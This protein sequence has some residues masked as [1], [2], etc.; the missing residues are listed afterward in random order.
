MAGIGT[1]P[2]ITGIMPD[3]PD[4][5]GHMN[6]N[7]NDSN[8]DYKKSLKTYRYADA[9]HDFSGT[10]DLYDSDDNGLNHGISATM[11][12]L[13]GRY[14]N[15][16]Y[17]AD[18]LNELTNSNNTSLT[19]QSPEDDFIKRLTGYDWSILK[20]SIPETTIEHTEY[21]DIW[22]SN[23]LIKNGIP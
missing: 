11:S 5:Q 21:M 20:S 14:P 10:T 23:N 9:N 13:L 18:E 19:N 1:T 7:R 15:I 3:N 8:Q 2:E 4:L 12:D 17:S 22:I 16:I 6:A